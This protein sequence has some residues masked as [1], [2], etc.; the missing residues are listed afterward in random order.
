M[1][2]AAKQEASDYRYDEDTYYPAKLIEVEEVEIS[3][4]KKDRRTG[5][6]TDQQ[7]TFK[8]W[9]W[10]FEITGT[11]FAG[12][13]VKGSTQAEYNTRS[14]NRLRE[15]AETLLGRELTVGEELDTDDLLQLPCM[16]GFKHAEPVEKKDGSGYWFNCEIVEVLPKSGLTDQ[17][18]F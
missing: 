2:K 16:L 9:E 17:V 6:K 14:D 1:P 8:K 15:W 18:P 5:L 10:L 11:D 4:F 3:Y 7:A 13:T 12:D